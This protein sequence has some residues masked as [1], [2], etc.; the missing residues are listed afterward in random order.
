[1]FLGRSSNEVM[2]LNI[3]ILKMK[4][5]VMSSMIGSERGEK[6]RDS[7]REKGCVIY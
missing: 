5:L 4:R 1:M 7:L 2:L 6:D 3:T